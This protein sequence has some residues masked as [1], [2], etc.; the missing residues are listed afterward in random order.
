ML[1]I[2]NTTEKN[3]IIG[4]SLLM[5]DLINYCR[6]TSITVNR[7]GGHLATDTAI[8]SFNR[9]FERLYRTKES[10]AHKREGAAYACVR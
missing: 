3:V 4:A 7:L 10:V 8:G 2:Y 1:H 5:E 6:C 9:E